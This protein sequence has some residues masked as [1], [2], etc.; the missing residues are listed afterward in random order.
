MRLP[1][2]P[3]TISP[4]HQLTRALHAPPYS[5]AS[6]ENSIR[7]AAY[8][9]K[10]DIWSLGITGI[11]MAL[12]VPPLSEY[13]RTLPSYPSTIPSHVQREC[14]TFCFSFELRPAMRVLFLIPKATP[15]VLEGDFSPA[16]KDF[17]AL[18]LTKNM[19]QVASPCLLE[20]SPHVTT[21]TR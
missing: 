1:L 3:F 13:H 11:E 10:A 12:G 18:C 4:S 2:P 5:F 15:P 17:V 6:R 21:E 16:F 8:D 20:P 7:Q 19:N 14:L 9:F